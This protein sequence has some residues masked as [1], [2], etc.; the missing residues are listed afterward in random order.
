MNKKLLFILSLVA[1]AFAG[2]ASAY[3]T[4]TVASTVGAVLADVVQTII[5][6]GIDFLTANLPLIIALGVAIGLVWFLIAKARGAI[7]GR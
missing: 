6:V 2:T 1:I 4:S 5:A 3:S 7:R